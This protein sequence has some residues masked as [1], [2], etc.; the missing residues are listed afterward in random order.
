M[1]GQRETGG[2]GQNLL[3]NV[4]RQPGSLPRKVERGGAGDGAGQHIGETLAGPPHPKQKAAEVS[5]AQTWAQTLHKE[6]Q[7]VKQYFNTVI[8]L[9]SFPFF[10]FFF[11]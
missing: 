4:L 5:S 9:F 10:S 2:G 11:F 1:Q 6:M 8:C 7:Y 3:L